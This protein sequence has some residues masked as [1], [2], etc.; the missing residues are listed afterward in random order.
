M[1]KVI[2]RTETTTVDENGEFRRYEET[3][4]VNIGSEPNYVKLYLNDILY[5]SDLPKGLNSV[6][7]AFLNRMHYGNEL[8]LNASLKKKIAK[9]INLSLSSIDNAIS[10]FVKGGIL[11]RTDPGMFIVNPHLFGKGEWRDISKIRL[12]V[13]FDKSGKTIM[14]EIERDDKPIAQ[15]SFENPQE[16]GQEIFDTYTDQD[17]PNALETLPEHL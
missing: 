16:S 9:E 5:L 8:V 14:A 7:L 11:E 17:Q 13:V 12:N 2:N 1:K 15:K 10:K 6:L 3:N 4:T